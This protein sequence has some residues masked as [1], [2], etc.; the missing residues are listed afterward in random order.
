MADRPG[1][2]GKISGR[3]GPT[4]IS[5][6]V[7]LVQPRRR[8]DRHQGIGPR[9]SHAA[10]GPCFGWIL[11]SSCPVGGVGVWAASASP[12][13]DA[14]REWWD[15]RVPADV[16]RKWQSPFAGLFCQYDHQELP[17]LDSFAILPVG[18]QYGAS[19]ALGGAPCVCR[20]E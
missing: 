8:L 19:A 16:R 20:S 5:R 13:V 1:V 3:R 14:L 11:S 12:E 7:P 6:I 15:C 18:V 10:P 2:P 17:V 4:G 9:A